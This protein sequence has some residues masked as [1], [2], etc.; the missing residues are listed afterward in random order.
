MKNRILSAFIAV[1]CAA[2]CAAFPCS[3]QDMPNV[4][5]RAACLMDA[6]TGELLWYK[7]ADVSMGMASTTKIMTALTVRALCPL[8]ATVSIPASAVG[9]EGSSVYLCEGERLTVEQL[10]YALILSSANDAA[11]ALATY[12]SGSVEAFSEEM[13]ARAAELGLKSTHFSNPH[14][15]DDEAHYTTARELALIT[16]EALRDDCLASIFATKKATIPFCDKPDGRLLVNHNKLL[17]TYEGAIGVKTGYTK[18]TGRCLVSAAE[19]DGM[20]LIAVTLNAPD[21]WR[22]H[23]ALL[24]YG[25]ASFE[26]RVFAEAGELCLELALTGGSSDTVRLTNVLPLALTVPRGYRDVEYR[27]YSCS[28]FAFAPI[29]RGQTLGEVRASACGNDACSPLIAAESV[30]AEAERTIWQKFFD[31]FK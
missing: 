10:L 23:T 7:D 15:L 14:G 31:I 1:C 24:D 29:A 8:D 5:A 20:T 16:R 30:S 28:H 12:C 22:D 26:R 27:I 19:R 21:D 13:N 18:S 9:I 25:F 17:S 4:S 6:A 11:V 3:A 2:L